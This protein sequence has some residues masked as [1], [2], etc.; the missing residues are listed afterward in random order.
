[1]INKTF[2][3]QKS[4][5]EYIITCTQIDIKYFMPEWIPN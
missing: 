5:E 1:M 4:T 2:P 3:M